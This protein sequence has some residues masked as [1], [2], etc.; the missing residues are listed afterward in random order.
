MAAWDPFGEFDRLRRDFERAAS[1]LGLRPG[2]RLAFLPGR[3]ARQYPL[4]NLHDDGEALQI[5]AL[6]P[7]VDPARIEVTVV[8]N[9]L[10]ISGEKEGPANVPS[11]RLHRAERAAGRFM[12]TIDLPVEVD[13]D[14]VEAIYQN[15]LLCLTLPRS[16]AAR[17]RK[18]QIQAQ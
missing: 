7:G 6:A 13:Q 10:T 4:I 14:R 3:A 12:R 17:P 2:Q 5:E 15:G 16:A 1:E 18:I 11:E 8:G 9:R